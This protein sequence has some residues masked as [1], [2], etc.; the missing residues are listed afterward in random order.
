MSYAELAAL[1][2]ETLVAP[3][4]AEQ[5]ASLKRARDAAGRISL[6]GQPLVAW[7][8]T[9]RAALGIAD[10]R[11][12][13]MTGHQA[14]IWHAGILSKW[15]VADEVACQSNAS[16]AA[17]VV[18]QD[19]NDASL[20]AYPTLRD[21]VLGSASLPAVPSRRSGPTGRQPPIRVG[22]AEAAPIPEVADA[23]ERIRRAVNE[24]SVM[25][26]IALQMSL[27]QSSLMSELL[28]LVSG[29]I[30]NVP[31]TAVL[32]T[33]FAERLLGAMQGDPEQCRAAYN[34]ALS[35]DPGVA[36][37]LLPGE[38]PLW[39]LTEGGRETVFASDMRAPLAPRALL[40]T[41]I[42]RLV[43]SDLF[44]HGTGGGRYERV[45]EA[46]IRGWLDIELPAMSIATATVR[47]PLGRFLGAGPAVTIAE[48]RRRE[49][50]PDGSERQLSPAMR[51][52]LDAVASA[53][54]RSTERRERY[55]ALMQHRQARRAAHAAE[56]QTLRD[57]VAH[58]AREARA[59]ELAASR[60]W[61][62]PLHERTVLA[63]LR[64]RLTSG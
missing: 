19:T 42:A 17:I 32:K 16:V 35:A 14:G 18:D 62:W 1:R 57:A 30:T 56:L 11:P 2:S 31:A 43:L 9:S 61:P 40:M 55:L 4:I 58:G 7:Q 12:V 45:T 50:D 38:L 5:I 59:A 21:G 48:L 33:P 41:A 10:D 29:P 3:A 28:G 64:A 60:T 15:I 26:N 24:S 53:P 36:R 25:P 27:A 44:I 8:R 47:L 37:A 23:L 54:R 13:V 46:W 34:A 51:E 20:I 39:R 63:E 6:F 49:F 52:K 22:P